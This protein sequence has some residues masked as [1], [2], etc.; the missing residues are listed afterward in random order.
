MKKNIFLA[1]LA[2]SSIISFEVCSQGIAI[3]NDGTNPD[4]S[5]ML[6]VSSTTKGL[7]IP[8]MTQTQRNAIAN[9]AAGLMIYQTTGTKGF[10]Y[11]SGTSGSPVWANTT[12]NSG[13]SL[14]GN[15]G[16]TSGTNFVGTIDNV[17]LTFKVYNQI[18]GKIDHQH[19]NTSLGYLS[20]ST[21]TTGAYNTAIGEGSLSSNST[22]SYN[23]AFGI[24]ALYANDDNYN[25]A[26]GY[27]ALKNTNASE[28]NI[29]VG[30]DAGDSYNNGYN[31][32]F[33]GANTDVNGAFYY[34][35]IAIGQGVVCT[36][37]SQAR[38]GNS[39]TNSIGGYANWTN[40]S[41]GRFKK[42]IKDNVIGLD[43]IMKL[44]PVTYNLDVTKLSRTL[45]EDHGS[46]INDDMKASMAAKEKMAYS[47]FVAQEVE[48]AA[49]ETGY[50]FSGVDKPKNEND[51]YGL[52]YAEFVVPLVKAVQEQQTTIDELKKQ[53]AELLNRIEKLEHK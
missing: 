36:A 46:N 48:K 10:Y 13:W 38:I 23:C 30:Y 25:T 28:Y 21:N 40:I 42:N 2:I 1:V 34:N 27:Y 39:A 44:K 22:G 47:G 50:D 15:S 19:A 9:P 33:L 4:P 29:A 24:Y 14:T 16:T 43:F 7:L 12:G 17:P 37:S 35:V 45:C 52:R 51:F 41:D 31:N 11:N 6:D 3:N 32:V 26:A 18:G 53:N 8:R 20:L 49:E 5:A